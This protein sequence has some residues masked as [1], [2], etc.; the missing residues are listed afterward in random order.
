MC[1]SQL[2]LVGDLSGASFAAKYEEP[3]YT[4]VETHP[5][6][7]L[8]DYGSRLLAEVTMSGARDE[9]ASD[10]FRVLAAYIFSKN[11]PE[12]SPIGMTIPVGQYEAEGEWR[13]WFS[14]PSRYSRDNLP[15]PSDPRIRILEQGPERLAV[16]SFSGRRD[17]S[18]FSEEA[19]QLE[20]DVRSAG[21]EPTGPATLAVYNGPFTPGPFRRNEVLL[22]VVAADAP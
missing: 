3:T 8:R 9:A 22:P 20:Q 13:M 15:P 1:V 21:L 10:A 18:S 4:V 11:T 5:G 17:K 7:E 19:L 12:G 6:F 16:R 14:M 2:R